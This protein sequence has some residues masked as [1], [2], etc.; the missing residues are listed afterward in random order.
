MPIAILLAV[1]VSLG[2]SFA[3]Q[4]A[5]PGDMLYSVKIGVN[6]NIRSAFALSANAEA[7][8]Q[9][10]LLEERLEEAQTLY[11]DGYLTTDAEVMITNNIKSQA[12]ITADAVAKCDTEVAADMNTR[13]KVALK[14]FVANIGLD[15]S[16]ASNVNASLNASALSE[17]TLA[18]DAFLADTKLR[19]DTLR[20]VVA[21]NQADIKADVEAEVTAKLDTAA[22]LVLEASG[23]V[24]ADARAALNGATVLIQEVEAKLSTLGQAEVDASTGVITDIDFSIDPMKIDADADAGAQGSGSVSGQVGSNEDPD[25]PQSTEPSSATDIDLDIAA[26]ATID[27]AIVR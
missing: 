18:I 7:K 14:S 6:E 16:L 24:E 10:D 4:G 1:F 5:V 23:K 8:L 11:A 22:L 15:S 12:K 2:T 27:T 19:V 20:T 9:V 17:E 25:A 13:V 21:K 26:D 3:A